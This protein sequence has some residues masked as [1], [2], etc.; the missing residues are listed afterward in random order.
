MGGFAIFHWLIVLLIIFLPAPLVAF[1]PKARGYEKLCWMLVC[2]FLSWIG[3]VI[4]LV[5]HAGR[6]VPS[7]N[8]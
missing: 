1:S 6:A 2:F 3:F 4:F 7:N 5:V 8:R